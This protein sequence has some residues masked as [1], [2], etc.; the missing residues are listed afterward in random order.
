[1]TVRVP[2]WKLQSIGNDFPLVHLDDLEAIVKFE[3]NEL[4]EVHRAPAAECFV[5]PDWALGSL[6]GRLVRLAIAMAD[7][8]RG[9]GGDGLLAV[10]PLDANRV[11]LRMFNPDGSEDFCG[12][13]LRCAAVHAHAMGWVGEAFTIE[14]LGRDV[15]VRLGDGRVSTELG[16]ATYAPADVPLARAAELF[17]EALPGGRVGSALST[18]STHTILP[19]KALPDD[20]TFVRESAALEVDPLFPA[21]T[22]VIWT[23]ALAPDHLRLRIWERGV[24]ETQGCGTGSTAAAVDHLRALG[25]G[26]RVRVDNPGGTLFVTWDPDRDE[27]LV[28]GTAERVYTGEFRETR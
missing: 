19:V 22:S 2:F 4:R 5:S 13:G 15:A 20:A 9:V 28:E 17:R 1:M 24:G 27:T 11:L 16:G 12:N 8:R 7:R 23:Q 18:G 14:H 21:R 6:D 25:H 10:K 26:G 3:S